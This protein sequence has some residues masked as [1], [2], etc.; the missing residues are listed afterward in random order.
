MK[1]LFHRL[2][3]FLLALVVGLFGLLWVAP[4]LADAGR[5][6]TSESYAELQASLEQTSDP[7]RLAEL[8]Q[9]QAAIASS[10]DRAQL[11]N[12]SSHN[13]GIFARYKK[14]PATTPARFYVLGPG[15]ETDDDYEPVGLLVPPEVSLS[16][17]DSGEVSAAAAPR[18][19]RVLEGEQ[20]E[21]TDAAPEAEAPD[22]VAYQLSLPAYSVETG[23]PSIAALPALNQNQLDQEPETAPLD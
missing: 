17:S 3:Q 5:F 14:D 19:L 1:T 13:L 21:L 10:D 2:R 8:Q 23:L 12:R 6:L 16:W 4:A 22:A 11:S 15:H 18:V 9:L 20:L 7:Q